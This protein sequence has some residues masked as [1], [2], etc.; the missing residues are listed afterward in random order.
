MS[1]AYKI[2]LKEASATVTEEG[3]WRPTL[4]EILEPA[5]MER[6]IREELIAQGW[7]RDDQ[8]G[9]SRELAGVRCE[10]PADAL[11]VRVALTDEVSVSQTVIAD[12]DDSPE[13]RR[14]R[15][16]AGEAQRDRALR[17]LQDERRRAM[18]T[19]LVE[20]EPLV[21]HELD[22]ALHRAH[23][24]ALEVKAAQLGEVQSVARTEGEDGELEMV[25]HVKMR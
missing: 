13:V 19:K 17:A 5:E 23:A 20:L 15:V 24:R 3:V 1:Y 12:S 25:I 8:G 7:T 16:E 11:E 14:Q 9:L 2:K 18:V 21:N 10:L 6:L 22:H 4:L